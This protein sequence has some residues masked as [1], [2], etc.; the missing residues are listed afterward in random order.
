MTP[1]TYLLIRN[2]PE[3]DTMPAIKFFFEMKGGTVFTVSD[4]NKLFSMWL[5]RI[6]G[7]RALQQ[8]NIYV[9]KELDHYFKEYV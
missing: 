3:Q 4:F 6:V 5:H 8:I 2:N 1:Y 9:F 7:I